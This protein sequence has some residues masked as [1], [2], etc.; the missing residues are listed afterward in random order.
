M[1]A[2]RKFTR[3]TV[4]VLGW[5]D[6][7]LCIVMKKYQGSLD[8]LIFSQEKR[9]I[10]LKVGLQILVECREWGVIFNKKYV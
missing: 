3:N 4:A 1:D 10:T 5:S 2:V 7:P 9:K 6:D 8:S